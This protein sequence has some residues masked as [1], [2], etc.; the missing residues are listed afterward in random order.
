MRIIRKSKEK[1]LIESFIKDFKKVAKRKESLKKRFSFVLTGGN[2]PI[3]LYKKLSKEKINWKN[4]D[5]FGEMKD[6]C[7]K[8][9]NFQS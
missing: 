1:L 6:S 8:D 5:F 4:V 3:N 7:Q 9:P 2:S